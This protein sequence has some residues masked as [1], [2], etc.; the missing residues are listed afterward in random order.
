MK[1]IFMIKKLSLHI[2]KRDNLFLTL[3]I[4]EMLSRTTRIILRNAIIARKN[5]FGP[6]FLEKFEIKRRM[7]LPS[8]K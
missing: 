1:L 2:R 3:L 5:Q 4:L 7:A 6:D 8:S